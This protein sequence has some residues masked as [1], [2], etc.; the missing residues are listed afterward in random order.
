MVYG[1]NG[2]IINPT[3]TPPMQLATL[4]LLNGYGN[5]VE[6]DPATG[7]DFM[8]SQNAAII[9][10]AAGGR[11]SYPSR[12]REGSNSLQ[13]LLDISWMH[14]SPRSAPGGTEDADDTVLI[15]GFASR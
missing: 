13:S 2:G 15:A 9:F 14:L 12:H 3:T 10:H 11:S 1:G 7:Y 4:S 5:G 8:I 6:P